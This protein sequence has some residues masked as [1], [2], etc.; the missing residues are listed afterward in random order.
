MEGTDA[1]SVTGHIRKLQGGR[2]REKKK[3]NKMETQKG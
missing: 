3:G 2:E 1:K